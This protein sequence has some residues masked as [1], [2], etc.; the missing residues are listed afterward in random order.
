MLGISI[1][2]STLGSPCFGK[3]PFRG[4]RD[5]SLQ[6]RPRVWGFWVEGLRGLHTFRGSGK[7]LGFLGTFDPNP[8][9]ASPKLSYAP[10][11]P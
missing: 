4:Q 11:L 6:I 7:L 10:G 8:E 2:G 9:A 1:L 3:L 5:P